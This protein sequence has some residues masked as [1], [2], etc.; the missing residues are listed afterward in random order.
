MFRKLLALLLSI[1]ICTSCI[2]ALAGDPTPIIPYEENEIP[3]LLEGQHHYLLMC[4]DQ[5]DFQKNRIGN[6]DG[7]ILLTI[8]TR[9]KRIMLTSFSR[10]ILVQRPDGITG[11]ITFITK[12]YGPEEM[13][14]IISSH[15]GIKVD[16]YFVFCWQH[17]ANIVDS[18]GGV[19]IEVND[20]EARYLTRYAIEPTA[21]SPS[22]ANAGTYKFYGHATVIYMR[23]RKVQNELDGIISKGDYGRTKRIRYV[24]GLLAD[25]CVH[26]DEKQAIKLLNTIMDN[27]GLT[28]LSIADLMAAVGYA[29]EVRGADIEELRMPP[30]DAHKIITYSG[31]SVMDLNYDICRKR[32]EEYLGNSFMVID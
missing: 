16:K 8:D 1:V 23:I 20:A 5:W 26:M 13:C 9:A 29:L 3:A 24:L 6:T 10:D 4:N 17:I 12:N 19:D 11:R 14:K 22:M 32:I 30:D 21:T 2:T 28:N 27:T 31:M 18:F 15:F 25:M 7:I